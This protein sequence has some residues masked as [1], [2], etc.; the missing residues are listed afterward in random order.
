MRSK[1]T[2]TFSLIL[3]KGNNVDRLDGWLAGWHSVRPFFSPQSDSWHSKVGCC[4]NFFL[5][6]D[7]HCKNV[8][9]NLEFNWL[10]KRIIQEKQELREVHD[11]QR[12][13]QL[14]LITDIHTFSHTDGRSVKVLYRG[15]FA[16]KKDISGSIRIE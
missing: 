7:L 13:I 12:A 3:W 1:N 8:V 5:A 2:Y 9:R 14:C 10:A 6:P 16:P 15:C 4:V 11:A